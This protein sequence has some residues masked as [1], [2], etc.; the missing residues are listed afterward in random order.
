MA[1][2]LNP[3]NAHIAMR[4]THVLIKQHNFQTQKLE[5]T[6]SSL[7][8]IAN[9]TSNLDPVENSTNAH[10]G[11]KMLLFSDGRQRAANLARDLKMLKPLTKVEQCSSTYTNKMVSQSIPEKNRTLHRLLYPYLCLFSALAR[12]NP[13][14][15]S[16]AKPE[17]QK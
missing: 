14:T 12:N 15:D 4:G 8:A 9:A 3:G 13:L 6:N 11:R 5:A 2:L 7:E 16:D 1:A 10:E 17:H